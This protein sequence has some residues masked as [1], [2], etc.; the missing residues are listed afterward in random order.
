MCIRFWTYSLRREEL[1][2]DFESF[3]VYACTDYA[4]EEDFKISF[5]PNEI[6][7]E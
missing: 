4:I 7:E 6:R 2:P 1:Q 3:S 5:V